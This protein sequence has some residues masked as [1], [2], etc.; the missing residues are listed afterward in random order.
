MRRSPSTAL[1]L[2]PTPVQ[3][4]A[5]RDRRTVALRDTGIAPEN[6]RY[7]EPPDEDIPLLAET[8]IAAGQLQPLTV[9]PGRGKKEQPHMA[10]DGRRR[11]LAF[12]HLLDQGRVDEEFPVD[13]VVDPKRQAAAVL[14]T[15]TAVPVH[16]A[17]VIAAIGR[18]LKGK[19]AVPV[20]ATA[21]HANELGLG[22]LETIADD[23]LR[24]L[25]RAGATFFVSRV[26]KKYL[27]ATKMFDTPN[28]VAFANLLEGLQSM[29]SRLNKKIASIIHDEQ[30]EFG[31]TLSSWHGLFSNASPDVIEWAGERYSLQRAPGSL[32]V[33]KPD[34]QSAGIQM[35]DVALWLYG[36]W[37]KGKDLPENCER[38][39]L[40]TGDPPMSMRFQWVK[41]HLQPAAATH[42]FDPEN[43]IILEPDPKAPTTLSNPDGLSGAPVFFVWQDNNNQAWLG[44]AGMV[45]NARIDRFAVYSTIYI[46]TALQQHVD[47]AAVE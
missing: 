11:I 22:R 5:A 41:V 45:T 31:R 18:M 12:R 25:H 46:R 23:L 43:R 26:E 17:D 8:L 40:F 21:I 24:L 7:K 44:L 16:V 10:L 37:L 36:Q 20:G 14:L 15:N 1:A 32:F 27:L 9:R 30:N 6:L 3:A 38:L 28:L 13:I 33:M 29:S 35:A 42:P 4:A 2:V 39:L 47:A 34:D 19:L